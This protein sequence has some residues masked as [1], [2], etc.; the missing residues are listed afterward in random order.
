MN[1]PGIL[2]GTGVS[3]A[4]YTRAMGEGRP[5][6][7]GGSGLPF[8]PDIQGMR[9]IAVLLVALQHAGVPH[10]TGG[11]VGVDVF[12]VLSGFLI[13]GLLLRR[14]DAT[15]S[16]GIGRFY[17]ARAKRILPAAT[18]T[19]V[20]VCVAAVAWLN[21][22]R[23]TDILHDAMWCAAF[24]ANIHFAQIGSDYFA[25][26]SPPSPL[27]HFWTLAVEEQFYLVWPLLLGLAVALLG[28]RRSGPGPRH[29]AVPRL[30]IALLLGVIIAA[31]LAWSITDTQSSPQTAYFSTFTRAWELA[32]GALLAVG[33]TWLSRLPAGLRRWLGWA[34][35]AGVLCAGTLYS[36][37]TAF[38]GYAALLPVG[39]AALLVVAGMGTAASGASRLLSRQPLTFVGDV[40]YSFY[41]WHWPAL[42]MPALYVGHDLTL[43]QNLLLLAAAFALS[44]ATY[45]LYENPIRHSARLA[46]RP[47]RPLRL[48]PIT[49]GV[50]VLVA[51]V[52]IAYAHTKSP[53][54]F[55]P[56]APELVS[57][58]RGNPFV[59]AV[60]ESVRP[61]QLAQPIPS[62]LAPL[63]D[64]LEK[65]RFDFGSCL[66]GYGHNAVCRLGSPTPRHTVVVFGDSHTR[67]WMP[68]LLYWAKRR[69]LTVIPLV[70]EG[71]VAEGWANLS[72]A[73]KRC[74]SWY[75]WALAEVDRLHPDAVV[76]GTRYSS[77]EGGP[78]VLRQAV[79]GVITEMHDLSGD[80][81]VAL[82]QDPPA[83]PGDPVDCILKSGAT[84]GSCAFHLPAAWGPLIEGATRTAAANQGVG[85]IPT[86]QLFCAHG[87]CPM[88]VRHIIVYMDDRGH[89]SETYARWVAPAFAREL[90]RVTGL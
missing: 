79:H 28:R 85:F 73:D 27:Q 52:G 41:L 45:R 61:S 67:M 65:D 46:A 31:S 15:G 24:A 25:Q 36:P 62:E 54:Q 50:V 11:Y 3:P 81:K 37:G 72:S 22:V 44:V 75:R 4:V 63:P 1:A 17:A 82:I 12:F 84:L 64:H 14:A 32:V 59:Q 23:A 74:S 8:R 76:I 58:S 13:T 43:R 42:I 29:V 87:T 10:V 2:P 26:A 20:T 30:P 40:S 7:P 51:Q 66:K 86:R 33:A 55:V 9:A 71:C 70:A 88:V 47:L 34:G 19:L 89:I 21:Y 56:K 49:L 5:S 78:D 35:L 18:L 6:T 83:P 53:V 48:W 57:S 69:H 39:A 80:R 77:V 68:G 38:P 90:T 60:V 16:V